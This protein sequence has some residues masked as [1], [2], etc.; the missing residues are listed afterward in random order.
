MLVSLS[1]VV[2]G[3]LNFRGAGVRVCMSVHR[4]LRGLLGLRCT[5]W[6]YCDNENL[7]V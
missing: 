5:A 4:G 6:K 2:A 3:G 1:L 7:G